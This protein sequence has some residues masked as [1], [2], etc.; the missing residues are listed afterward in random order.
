MG[1]VFTSRVSDRFAYVEQSIVVL[2]H[3][4]D[5]Y[6]KNY[7][8]ERLRVLRVFVGLPIHR[9]LKDCL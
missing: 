8:S 6:N 3:S 1:N 9:F 5:A 2:L 4:V 7:E